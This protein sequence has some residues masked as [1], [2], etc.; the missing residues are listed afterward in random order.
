MEAVYG[1]LLPFAGT[2]LGAACVFGMR[3]GLSDGIQ[4][5]LTGFAAGVMTAASV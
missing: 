3:Q 5:G 1:V 4:R 2:V